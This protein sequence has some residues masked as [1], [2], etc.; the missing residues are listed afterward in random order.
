MR[1]TRL[2]AGCATFRTAWTRVLGRSRRATTAGSAA[3]SSTPSISPARRTRCGLSG[4]DSSPNVAYRPCAGFLAISG[5]IECGGSRSPIS[6]RPSGS[7][8]SAS[9]RRRRAGGRGLRIRR[10]VK[11][12]GAWAG[13][14]F[15][16]P[17]PPGPTASCSASSSRIRRTCRRSH[18]HPRVSSASPQRFLPECAHEMQSRSHRRAHAG[19][20]PWR[21][22]S[23]AHWSIQSCCEG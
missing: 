20:R 22:S 11:R 7:R 1:S 23:I 16:R 6:R 14:G 4:T 8:A 15:S 17:V 10:W 12:S 19:R 21:T 3:T 2:A 5:A 13:P 18:S 9:N